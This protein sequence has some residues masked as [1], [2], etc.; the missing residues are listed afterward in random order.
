VTFGNNR[1]N[2]V[3]QIQAGT[4]C[5]GQCDVHIPFWSYRR[6]VTIMEQNFDTKTLKVIQQEKSKELNAELERIDSKIK[7]DKKLLVED[8]AFISNLGWISILS[9][10]ITSITM[11][12]IGAGL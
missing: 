2:N 12:S 11:G 6:E 1:Q 9:V 7:S 3:T 8:G 5:V 4:E 10:T